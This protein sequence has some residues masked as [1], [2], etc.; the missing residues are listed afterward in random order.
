VRVEESCYPAAGAGGVHCR[1]LASSPIWAARY[2]LGVVNRR[3]R[4]SDIPGVAQW[5]NRY[6]RRS[7]VARLSNQ[8]HGRG[9]V[10]AS[11]EEGDCSL[12]RAAVVELKVPTICGGQE[13]GITILVDIPGSSD[14]PTIRCPTWLLSLVQAAAL[15]RPLAEP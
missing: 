3:C 7:V 5:S 9:S 4:R 14:S 12:R 10:L 13:V 8:R 15:S 6:A 1:A 11:I 2:S